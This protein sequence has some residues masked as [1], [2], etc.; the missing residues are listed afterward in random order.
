MGTAG[1]SWDGNRPEMVN[2]CLY[3]RCKYFVGCARNKLSRWCWYIRQVGMFY[4]V[5]R[6]HL[7]A[8]RLRA[9]GVGATPILTSFFPCNAHVK[10]SHSRGHG[11]PV[12]PPPPLRSLWVMRPFILTKINVQS[13]LP[14]PSNVGTGHCRSNAPHSLRVTYL[15]VAP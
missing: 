8:E 1:V 10:I 4:V 9:R 5:R 3:R 15:S 7:A 6:D 2:N 14:T 11:A 13:C 12:P